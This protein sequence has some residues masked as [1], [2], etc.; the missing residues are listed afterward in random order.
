MHP[1]TPIDT[2]RI[3]Q[4]V[5]AD[6]QRLRDLAAQPF[7]GRASSADRS[8][9][10]EVGPGG[11]VRSVRLTPEALR[12]GGRWLAQQVLE[13]AARATAKVN[14]RTQL[15]LLRAVDTGAGATSAVSRL[16]LGYDPHLVESDPDE[17]R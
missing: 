2:G 8:I 17:W 15:A 4:Q 16:G 11:A 14:E 9:T 6:A 7:T 13:V 3:D 10:V 12:N 5:A 1:D